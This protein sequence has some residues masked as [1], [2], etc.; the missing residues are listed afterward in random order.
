[1]TMKDNLLTADR[2]KNIFI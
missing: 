1:M 2:I